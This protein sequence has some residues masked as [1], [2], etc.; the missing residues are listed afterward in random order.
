MEDFRLGGE[1]LEQALNSGYTLTEM[2]HF[3]YKN[4]S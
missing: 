3:G 4:S 1:V 2:E